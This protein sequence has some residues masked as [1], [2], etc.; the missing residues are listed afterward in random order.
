[1]LTGGNL[2]LEK[3]KELYSGYVAMVN[4]N[5][6]LNEMLWTIQYLDRVKPFSF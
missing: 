5:V 2:S 4:T 6:S 3:A 1:M